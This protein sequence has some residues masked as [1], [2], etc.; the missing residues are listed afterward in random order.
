MYYEEKRMYWGHQQLGGNEMR[1]RRKFP[2][3]KKKKRFPENI[4]A[5]PSKMKRIYK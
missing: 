5:I 4:K 1:L 3:E 2:G